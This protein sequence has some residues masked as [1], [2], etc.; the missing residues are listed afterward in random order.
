MRN[1]LFSDEDDGESGFGF[2]DQ[3]NDEA[4]GV[5]DVEIE[6]TSHFA[7]ACTSARGDC[8]HAPLFGKKHC[9]LHQCPNCRDSKSS[10]VQ[11]CASCTSK[12][13]DRKTTQAIDFDQGRRV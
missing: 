12:H 9:T 13:D 5:T 7:C 6:V 1:P 11:M 10:R 8:S 4:F 3:A 2:G